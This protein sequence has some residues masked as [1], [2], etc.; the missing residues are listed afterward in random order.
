MPMLGS[1]ADAA[2]QM[3]KLTPNLLY[4]TFQVLV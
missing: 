1:I 4:D 3:R 2:F